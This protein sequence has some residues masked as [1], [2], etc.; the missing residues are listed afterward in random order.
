MGLPTV[1]SVTVSAEHTLRHLHETTKGFLVT[2]PS[3]ML[4]IRNRPA[5][6]ILKQK[7]YICTNPSTKFFTYVKTTRYMNS[8]MNGNSCHAVASYYSSETW[9]GTQTVTATPTFTHCMVER[10]PRILETATHRVTSYKIYLE[11][12]ERVELHWDVMTEKRIRQIPN[13]SKNTNKVNSQ[14]NKQLLNAA[15]QSGLVSFASTPLCEQFG[16]LRW[17]V[18]MTKPTQICTDRPTERMWCGKE[19]HV[20]RNGL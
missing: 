6:F 17:Y 5:V 19:I 7:K 4:D 9:Q 20:G 14:K 15:F 11:S 18:C 8:H 10:I 16:L 12:S 1:I 2:T 13:N 3:M